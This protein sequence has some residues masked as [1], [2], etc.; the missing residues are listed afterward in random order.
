RYADH[1]QIE[2]DSLREGLRRQRREIA[3]LTSVLESLPDGIVVQD[4]DGRVA[5][6]NDKAK[7]LLG[8]QRVFRSAPFQ[9]LTALVT[10]ILGPA[11]APGL[12]SLGRPQQIELEGRMVS[13]QAAA[14]TS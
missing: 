3:H 8:S 12:Y 14:I 1:V 4:L 13:A 2:H 5:L 6:M 9:E 11:L 10:D 7:E